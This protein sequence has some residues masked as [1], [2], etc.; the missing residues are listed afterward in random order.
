MDINEAALK[1]KKIEV[2][3]VIESQ[4]DHLQ[5]EADGATSSSKP[6][7]DEWAYATDCN[8][9]AQELIRMLNINSLFQ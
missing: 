5:R 2:I 7:K 3:E 6:N 1:L 9:K 4:V 8:E